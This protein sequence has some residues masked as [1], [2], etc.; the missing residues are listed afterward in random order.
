MREA[1]F[2]KQNKDKWLKFENVLRNNIQM[3]PDEL[4]ALY[5]EITD[6][7]SYA[8]TFYPN[9]NTLKYLNGL[10]VLAHQKNL[11]DQAGIA[12][13]LHHFLYKGVS[14]VFFTIPQTIVDCLCCISAFFDR[15]C[16]FRSYR[17][18]FCTAN[19]G[20]WLCEYDLG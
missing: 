17:W 13:P 4:S 14:A 3:N 15:W 12:N 6:H 7:L 8:Q 5:I 18:Q 10:S 11:Q 1:A 9:S 16:L 20:R 19:F 2:A